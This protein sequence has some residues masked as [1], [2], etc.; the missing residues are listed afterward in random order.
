[1]LNI[2]FSCGFFR[3]KNQSE[4]WIKKKTLKTLLDDKER[5]EFDW[6]GGEKKPRKSQHQE[7]KKTET[8]PI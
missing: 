6:A 2:F 3:N 1:M 7:I 8:F 5:G 4:K